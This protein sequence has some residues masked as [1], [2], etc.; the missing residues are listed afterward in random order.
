MEPSDRALVDRA[1]AGDAGAFGLLVARH[2]DR[3]FRVAWR[4]L[5]SQADAEDLAQD[6]CAALPGKLDGFRAEARFT[7]WLHRVVVN[8]ARDRLRR[9]AT[10]ARAVQGWGD[11]ETLRRDEARQAADQQEWL[12][13]AMTALPLDLRET[14]A[15]VLGEEMTHAEAA[16]AL[17]VSEGTVSWRM[18]EVRKRLRRLAEEERA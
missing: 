8:A 1:L 18:S 13:R 16:A 6:V 5:G 11:V 2:Y 15:L 3:I 14:V 10:H 9:H 7:T 17:G 12:V 4:V